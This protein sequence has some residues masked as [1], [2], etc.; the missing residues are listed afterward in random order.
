MRYAVMVGLVVT[1]GLVWAGETPS[2]WSDAKVSE[3]SLIL[4]TRQPRRVFKKNDI[5][6]IIVTEVSKASG[7][8]E[9]KRERDVEH[10][11]VINKWMRLVHQGGGSYT[12]RPA[13]QEA[14][15]D[16]KPGIDLKSGMKDDL[17]GDIK[18]ADK[19]EARIAAIVRDVKPNGNLVVEAT[20][21]VE[22]NREKVN[23]TLTGIVRAEDVRA[24]NT[25]PSYNIAM[26]NIRYKTTGPASAGARRGWLSAIIDFLRPF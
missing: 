19:M 2:F 4:T 3:S 24:D 13:L 17:S 9:L 15:S 21:L 7:S 11:L 6:T 8:G 20:R 23:I 18:R 25:V 16:V 10:D 26:A 14:G 5:I 1:C 22:L 12:L